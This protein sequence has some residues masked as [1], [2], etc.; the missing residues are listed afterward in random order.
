MTVA[1]LIEL[2]QSQDPDAHH[3]DKRPAYYAAFL[4]A[5]GDAYL[6]ASD[7]ADLAYL[8]ATIRPKAAA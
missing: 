1:D 6:Q 3:V 5:L 4:V 7:I 2:L 8:A